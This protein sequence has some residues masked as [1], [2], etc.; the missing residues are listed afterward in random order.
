MALIVAGLAHYGAGDFTTRDHMVTRGT[1]VAFA[2]Y[3]FSARFFFFSNLDYLRIS[4]RR[5]RTGGWLLG[6][7]RRTV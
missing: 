3:G 2:P 5:R 4:R 7:A 6:L 1:P